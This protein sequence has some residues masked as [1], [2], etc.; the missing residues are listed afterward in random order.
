MD[1][2]Y[3]ETAGNDRMVIIPEKEYLA[4]RLIEE[5]F[6]DVCDVTEIKSH[7]KKLAHGEEELFPATLI[8]RLHAGDDHPIKIYREY[9][10]LK[11]KELAEIVGITPSYL[12]EIENRKK[13]GTLKLCISI[14]RALKVDLDDLVEWPQ[15]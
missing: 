1:T 14:A 10:G 11:A 15:D 6:D 4:L 3:I 2:Q 5:R 12:S 7:L 8:E 9:R 13:D